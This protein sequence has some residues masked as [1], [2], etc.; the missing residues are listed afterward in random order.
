MGPLPDQETFLIRQVG[1]CLRSDPAPSGSC[2]L[3]KKSYLDR[4]LRTIQLPDCKHYVHQ[5]CL[6]SHFRIRDQEWEVCPVCDIALCQR[7]LAD[8]IDTDREA[9]FDR[10]FTEFKNAVSIEFPQRSEMAYCWSDEEVAATQLRLLKDYVDVHA[11]ELFRTWRSKRTEPDWFAMVVKPVVELFRG[12]NI[13]TRRSKYFA[14]REA[15]LKVIVWAELV[16]LMNTTRAAVR[17][18]HGEGEPFPQ[19]TGLHRWFMRTKG[20]YE[21]E[22]KKWRKDRNGVLLCDMIQ[23]EATTPSGLPNSELPNQK[24]FLAHEIVPSRDDTVLPPAETACGVCLEELTEPVSHS[25]ITTVDESEVVFLDPCQHFFHRACIVNWHT[26]T[27]PERDTCPIC[28]RVLFQADALTTEQ[29]QHLVEDI[30]HDH[31]VRPLGPYREPGPNERLVEW[32][33]Y[34]LASEAE[35]AVRQ[36]INRVV[37]SGGQHD[38]MKV[39]RELRDSMLGINGTLRPAFEPYRDTV[40][41]RLHAI[42]MFFAITAYDDA[43]QKRAFRK[44][45]YWFSQV[46]NTRAEVELYNQVALDGLYVLD[47]RLVATVSAEWLQSQCDKVEK[48]ARIAT[49]LEERRDARSIR[50]LRERITTWVTRGLF[51]VLARHRFDVDE[52][53][54]RRD[55][56][57][58]SD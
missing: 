35:R 32:G 37:T 57:T 45:Y 6:L 39:C 3:C 29:I 36:E 41:L 31:G 52:S 47:V 53:S 58:R 34:V 14:D 1:V 4:K 28:R 42:P 40:V 30:Y 20:R 56:G 9:I 2:S 27:R 51:G 26:S 11:E 12:W 13:P 5:E 33:Q 50:G 24:E 17:H 16:R 49:D 25:N 8:R 22:K 23:D 43:I 54:I 7:T 21:D 55:V 10:Q 44:F 18:R 48:F 46:N 15:F 19:L 38:W